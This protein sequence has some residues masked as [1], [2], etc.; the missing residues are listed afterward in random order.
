M[1]ITKNTFLES[2][3]V[4]GDGNGG[5]QGAHVEYLEVIKDGDEELARKILPARPIALVPDALGPVLSDALAAALVANTALNEQVS[6]TNAAK[7]G[8]DAE[9]DKAI[10]DTKV[11]TARIAELTTQS[12]QLT[13]QIAALT[14]TK[15]EAEAARDKA[16]TD[17]DALTQQLAAMTDTTDANGVPLSVTMVQAQLALLGA[18]LLDKVSEAIAAIPGDEG[19]AARITWDKAVAVERGHPLIKAM[20]GALGMSDAD[21]DALFVAAG[22][23]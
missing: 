10:E 17:V 9:R 11:A 13:E 15:T 5:I 22:K 21:I 12:A 4:R 23:L 6:A 18:G 2:F 19:R 3:F 14:A 1:P 16:L 20:Q 8:A 7:A